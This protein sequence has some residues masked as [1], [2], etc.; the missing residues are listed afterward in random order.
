MLKG[1]HRKIKKMRLDEKLRL[2]MTTIIILMTVAMI[3]TTAFSSIRALSR[4]SET[5]A[6]SQLSFVSKFY[7]DWLD[8][9]KSIGLALQMDPSVQSFCRF[10]SIE[11]EDYPVEKS[12]VSSVIANTL[13][14]SPSINFIGIYNTSINTYAY[15]GNVALPYSGFEAIYGLGLQEYEKSNEK[16][17]YVVHYNENDAGILKD[18]VCFYQKIYSVNSLNKSI[19]MLCMN[20]KDSLLNNM[21]E[22]ISAS[23]SMILCATD[24]DGRVFSTTDADSVQKE[25]FRFDYQGK[26]SGKLRIGKYICF[27]EKV[28]GWNYYIVSIISAWDYFRTTFYALLVMTV[29]M[30]AIMMLSIVFGHY[31]AKKNYE[32]VEKVVEAMDRISSNDLTARVNTED[33]GVDFEKLGS[34]FNGMMNDINRLMVKNVE[35]QHQLDQI[36]FNSLQSQIQPHFLYNTL[37]CIHWQASADG[38]KEVSDLVIALAAY[39][40]ICLSKGKDIIPLRTELEQIRYYLIIQNKRY[41]DIIHYENKVPEQYL[42]VELPKLTLQPLVEN[43]IYHGIRVKEGL[44]GTVMIE[45]EEENGDL[46]IEVHDTGSG[47]TEKEVKEMNA[48]ISEYSEDFGYGVRNVSRRIRLLY[49]EKYGLHFQL[50]QDG[51]LSVVIRIPV[52]PAK[53]P[54]MEAE[55]SVHV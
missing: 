22:S 21:K 34:G 31:L 37:D 9:Y 47:M 1:L 19:G 5:M 4:Q 23:G 48:S 13:N 41:G 55:E 54:E 14:M 10:D 51:T 42:D 18:S 30:F 20:A 46:L 2:Y 35:E 16:G 49:G 17:T 3:F 8:S 32:P 50:H 12:N 6:K 44:S 24:N 43:S 40:R 11:N 39:Y 28:E 36:R 26:A 25:N 7:A 53:T 38:N 15:S 27:Y 33:M 29:L 52:H 45:A